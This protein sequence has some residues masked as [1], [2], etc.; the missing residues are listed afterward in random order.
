LPSGQLFQIIFLMEGNT[1]LSAEVLHMIFLHLGHEDLASLLLVCRFWAAAAGRPGLWSAARLLVTRTNAHLAPRL[2]A[3]PRLRSLRTVT[4]SWVT[5]EVTEAIKRHPAIVEVHFRNVPRPSRKHRERHSTMLQPAVDSDYLAPACSR[6]EEVWLRGS[7]LQCGQL[8]RLLEA[9]AAG[10]T[11]LR[12]LGLARLGS[13]CPRSH[14]AT[15]PVPPDLL[16]RAA[17]SLDRLVLDSL[18]HSLGDGQKQEFFLALGSS[19]G[20]RELTL[21]SLPLPG[22][23][24]AVLASALSSRLHRLNLSNVGL[25][26]EQARELFTVINGGGTGLQEL[27]VYYSPAGASQ[28]R[29]PLTSS[30]RQLEAPLLAGALNLRTRVALEGVHLDSEQAAA[31]LARGVVGSKLQHLKLDRFDSDRSHLFLA[32]GLIEQLPFEFQFCQGSWPY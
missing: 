26:V 28:P 14:Q 29:D 21:S 18:G 20:L 2:L 24:P 5:A 3:L 31:V 4:V 1:A 15:C 6:L 16:G 17:A 11:S 12:T 32:P 13:C 7:F 8:A 9:L 30:V 22:V 10:G 19:P 23:S 27:S 25:T